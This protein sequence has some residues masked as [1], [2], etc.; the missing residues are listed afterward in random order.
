[1]DLLDLGRVK[2]GEGSAFSTADKINS[3]FQ[4][5]GLS[6]LTMYCIKHFV[7][8]QLFFMTL[9]SL[10]QTIASLQCILP[11]YVIHSIVVQSFKGY[12]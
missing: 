9:M 4:I 12:T 8:H 2:Q 3:D 10:A 1:M 11:V 5:Q 7:L 6:K